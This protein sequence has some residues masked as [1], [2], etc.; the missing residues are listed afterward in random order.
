MDTYSNK[1]SG[2]T[3]LADHFQD[4]RKNILG[5]DHRVKTEFG[6]YPMVYTDWIAEGRLY[7]PIEDKMRSLAPFVAN[8]HSYSSYTGQIITGLYQEARKK[9]KDHVHARENDILVM[10]GQGMTGAV[11][12]LINILRKKFEW[13]KLSSEGE[14]V[15]FTTH[16]EHHS[17]L[18]VWDQAG[19]RVVIVPPDEKGRV[20]PENLQS[21]LSEHKNR[22]LKIGSFSGSSNVSGII[23]PYHKMAVKMHENDGLCFVDFAASA[24]YVDMNMHP[25][26]DMES[27]DAIFFAPHKFLGGP[28]TAGVLV[29]QDELHPGEPCL[30]SGGNVKWA[31]PGG[32]FGYS[33]DKE[34]MEDP[35]T[36]PYLQTIKTA[37]AIELK[38]QMGIE[39]IKA[40][41]KELLDRALA[42]L[43]TNHN[44]E[45]ID[46]TEENEKIG[47]ISFN[48]TDMHYNLVVR[49]LND[50]FGIQTR[51]GWSCA[52]TYAQYLFDYDKAMSEMLINR[53]KSGDMTGKPGWVRLS[54]H[55]TMTDEEMEYCLGAIREIIDHREDWGG[56]YEYNTSDNE[57]YPI[58]PHKT[59]KA[60]GFFRM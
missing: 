58:K 55:P 39:N 50:R 14:I 49:L 15:V 56:E 33:P 28:G 54:L 34:A 25:D 60:E 23:T 32:G 48:I 13:E 16:M 44:V 29:L 47:V 40:R 41:E 8:P 2:S 42:E 22:K 9:I 21:L 26:N 10:V 11:E 59:H 20:S 35:G 1:V 4:F 7:G 53:M 36:P 38:E 57:Y 17:N 46:C 18:T 6:D 52:S 19:A 31:L 43:G 45:L 27:L 51:G 12:R 3:R 30:T 37:L 5:Y 24:P